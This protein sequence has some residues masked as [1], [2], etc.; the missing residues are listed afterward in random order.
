MSTLHEL[1]L[2]LDAGAV[3]AVLAAPDGAGPHPALLVL[4]ELWGLT[5][6]LRR[7][8][9]RL[10]GE[11]YLAL[12]PELYGPGRRL[13][14]VSRAIRDLARGGSQLGLARI[15]QAFR[16]L[17]ER[18]E[19]DPERLGAIGFCMGG[20]FALL[21]GARAPARTVSVNYGR[22]PER[23]EE[24]EGLCPVVASY[25]GRDRLLPDAERLERFLAARDIP[26]DL[27]IYPQAGHGF[28]NHSIPQPLQRALRP[29]AVVGYD[30]EAAEDA[31]PR[32]LAFLDTHLRSAPG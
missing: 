27:K 3:P 29:L 20:G 12:A 21:L 24:L 28:L 32:I 2:R 9:A 5:D 10:A 13:A 11:G 18:P 14:C 1:E 7:I 31:W 15:E 26:Y 25:G 17:R 8:A 6:D 4:S 30:A 19:A 22:V 23:V 16:A